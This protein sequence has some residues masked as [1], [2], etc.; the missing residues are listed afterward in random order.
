MSSDRPVA[1]ADG[2]DEAD[3][4]KA[5]QELAKG[6]RAATALENQLSAMEAKIEALL[7]QAERDQADAAAHRAQQHVTG[8]ADTK[9]KPEQG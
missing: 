8:D 4:A 9:P 5:F 3:L 6:E 2:S 1:S 7:A